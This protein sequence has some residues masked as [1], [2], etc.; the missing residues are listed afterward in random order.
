M[1]VAREWVSDIGVSVDNDISIH[2]L[3]SFFF[4]R[5]AVWSG[6]KRKKGR[7]LD[8]SVLSTTLEPAHRERQFRFSRASPADLPTT[9]VM[10]ADLFRF[11]IL[12]L[13]LTP[14]FG[15][16]SAVADF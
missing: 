15:S 12:R 16:L 10:T 9:L 7:L 11:F 2:V 8:S 1:I 5:E 3:F 13:Q 6:V 14:R 4:F